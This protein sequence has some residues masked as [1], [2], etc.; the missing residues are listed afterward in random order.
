MRVCPAHCRCGK[1]GQLAVVRARKILADAADLG[2][3]QVEIVEEPFGGR[4]DELSAMHIVGQHAY[5]ARSTRAL[6]RKRGKMRFA[7]AVTGP[8]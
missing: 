5:V 3:D 2:R 4:R 1:R 7:R 8:R 6:S